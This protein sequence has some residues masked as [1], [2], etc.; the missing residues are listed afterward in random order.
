M[1]KECSRKRRG[2]R[3]LRKQPTLELPTHSPRDHSSN[4]LSASNPSLQ[5]CIHP[6]FHPMPFHQSITCPSIQ[7]IYSSSHPLFRPL[8]AASI[9]LSFPFSL[10]SIHPGS[11]NSSIRPSS[12]AFARASF[13]LSVHSFIFVLVVWIN[14]HC[15]SFGVTN[16]EFRPTSKSS[17]A[18]Y[19]TCIYC[20]SSINRPQRYCVSPSLSLLSCIYRS[21]RKV[22]DTTPST[23]TSATPF[24]GTFQR[25][26]QL[27]NWTAEASLPRSF[28]SSEASGL[29]T[30]SACCLQVCRASAVHCRCLSTRPTGRVIRT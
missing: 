27:S 18:L 4:R 23:L 2:G 25:I 12:H 13:L 30:F 6:L 24:V 22:R 19:Q 17:F 28:G 14:H 20:G 9:H 1:V 11:T 16:L 21:R 10:S 8:F 5:P 7:S 26:G 15:T 29:L 3:H